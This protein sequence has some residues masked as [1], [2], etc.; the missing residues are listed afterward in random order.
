MGQPVYCSAA[1][2]GMWGERDYGDGSTPYAW[3]AV[4]PSFH[5]CPAFLHRYFPSQSLPSHPLYLSLHSQ[6]QPLPWD[7][8]TI[9]KLQLLAAASS[10]GP[11]TLSRVCM[12]ATRT[13]W[14]SFH[15][16]CHRSAVSLSALKVPPLTQT[17]ALIWE[18]T[19][20]SVSPPSES[21]SSPTN[22][23]VFPPGSFV[24]PSFAWFYIF[25]SSGQR[26]L[27]A[28]S[29]CSACTSVSEG[30]FLMYPWRETYSTSTYSSTILFSFLSLIFRISL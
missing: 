8:S 1:H 21:K 20:A 15:L 9:P 18:W 24:L 23:P 5:D 29:W 2:T 28:L 27:S 11:V 3:L 25:F 14:F 22:T 12:S 19:P 17:I 30:V 10:R 6:Q 16:G 4:T 13:I 7:C 26:L